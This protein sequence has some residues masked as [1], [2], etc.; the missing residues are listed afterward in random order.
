M[1]GFNAISESPIS[2]LSG[3]QPTTATMLGEA[4]LRAI[5]PTATAFQ[6][7]A[8]ASA[9]FKGKH[10]GIFGAAMTVVGAANFHAQA[11]TGLGSASITRNQLFDFSANL[12]QAILWQYD[13]APQLESLLLAKQSWWDENF[14][15]FWEDWIVNVFDIRTCNDFGAAV[16][17][18]ILGIPLNIQYGET[19]GANFGFGPYQQNFDRS[20]FAPL[21]Y[22]VIP[23]SIDQ[24]R[25]VLQLRY[26]QLITRGTVP[27]INRN[28]TRIFAP[29]GPAWVVDNL[30]M[31]MTY[32]FNFP[33][34]SALAFILKFYNLL[35]APA[36]VKVD[37]FQNG[38][39]VLT[40]KGAASVSMRSNHSAFAMVGAATLRGQGSIG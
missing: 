35:P 15:Q 10:L 20:N 40:V 7:V 28:L 3:V 38:Q 24:K 19:D 14:S 29:L 36:G 26:Y 21:N 17:S 16:W 34:P 12:A 32:V 31:T 18:I 2:D 13:T 39:S 23:L 27:D 11:F 37:F 5:A 9:S 25:L 33:I 4:T 30:D 22:E 6:V 8:G 1:L